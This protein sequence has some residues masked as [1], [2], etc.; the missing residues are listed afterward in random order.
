MLRAVKAYLGHESI[1]TSAEI[2][3]T[4]LLGMQTEVDK[5]SEEVRENTII[6]AQLL[7]THRE[8][9]RDAR[10]EK[11]LCKQSARSPTRKQMATPRRRKSR[12]KNQVH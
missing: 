1:H 8:Y 5:K 2:T 12:R 6:Y 4:K 11:E 3:K 9:N 7:K 10:I